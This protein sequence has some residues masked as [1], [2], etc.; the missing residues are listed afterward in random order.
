MPNYKMIEGSIQHKFFLSRK[1]VQIF[2]GGY[3][4]GKTTALCIKALNVA[5]DYPGAEIL[6]ARETYP[7]LNDTVRKVFMLWC[8]PTWIKKRPTQEDNTCYM[9]NG[10]VINF[11]YIA[12][13]GKQSQDG[14]TTSNLLSATYD[15]IGVDQMEDPMIT[16][17][18]FD[19]LIGR[20]RGS[21]IYR[22]P[23]G[24][25]DPT[26]PDTGPRWFCIT[27]NPSQ[28][29]IHKKIVQP[30]IVWRDRGIKMDNLLVDEQTGLPIIDLFEGST[31]TNK[32]N[33]P[34]DYIRNLESAYKG[35]AR[36]R[37]LYGK[38][39][40]FEGLVY[41]DFDEARH[42]LDREKI[43][44][45]L[46]DCK[47]RHV[48]LTTIEGYDFGLTSPTCYICAFTDDY[49]RVFIIDGFYKPNFSYLDHAN[50]IKRIRAKYIG[51][52]DF[53]KK[54]IA[55]PAIF[56]A[57]VVSGMR[58]GE[59]VRAIIEKQDQEIRF[60][61]GMSDITQGIAKVSAYISGLVSSPHIKTG[62]RP[63]PL[64][65]VVEDLPYEGG[66]NFFTDE[67]L[68]YYWKKNPFGARIDEPVDNNDHAM[69]AVKY[70]LSR[71][72]DPAKIVVPEEALPPGWKF[73]HEEEERV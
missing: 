69:D 54:I 57:Q 49:G 29:W 37:Y 23:G 26:M 13:R 15:F 41:G 21:A 2:G 4:N 45:H 19:D 66:L 72:P 62:E 28:A 30:F 61:P 64:L 48:K 34:A 25:E 32:H 8:P 16:P 17:K 40:A 31:Y 20:L 68:S 11:R 7:K 43:M 22:P 55:D 39:A 1:A 59:T 18:D 73:W 3:G 44:S 63:G 42:V 58:S 46:F 36:E 10:S 14:S 53:N 50:E 38:H 6:L 67:I 51:L 71:L 9:V 70:M 65:Y 35:Q 12:Q 47:K 24:L 52:L 60:A 27:V 5:R 33:L 56:R